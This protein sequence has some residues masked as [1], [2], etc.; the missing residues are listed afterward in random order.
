MSFSLETLQSAKLLRDISVG[1]ERI[2]VSVNGAFAP[3]AISNSFGTVGVNEDI[4]HSFAGE[5]Y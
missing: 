4:R 2:S 1:A 5:D 3:P